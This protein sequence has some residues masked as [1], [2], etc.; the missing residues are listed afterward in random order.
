MKVFEVMVLIGVV[1]LISLGTIFSAAMFQ[2]VSV[3]G[4][5]T[6]ENET[7]TSHEN[8]SVWIYIIGCILIVAAIIMAFK[9]LQGQ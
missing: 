7:I 8:V 5:N 6:Y 2:S 4:N 1:A 9:L 3:E